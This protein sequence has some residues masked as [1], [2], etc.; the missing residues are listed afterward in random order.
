MG[1][2]ELMPWS[3]PRA[4]AEQLACLKFWAVSTKRLRR[5]IYTVCTLPN[6]SLTVISPHS[7]NCWK[8]ADYFSPQSYNSA[9]VAGL[10]DLLGRIHDPAARE[11]IEAMKTFRLWGLHQQVIGP[12]RVHRGQLAGTFP[13]PGGPVVVEA[14]QAVPRLEPR[15]SWPAGSQAEKCHL[16]RNQEHSGE[17]TQSPQMD[18]LHRSWRDGGDVRGKAASVLSCY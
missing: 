6:G 7:C 3:S 9:F 15:S 2:P 4:V 12:S 14:R 16:E 11:Q 8:V 1:N 13:R 5:R 10:D 17:R 18:D